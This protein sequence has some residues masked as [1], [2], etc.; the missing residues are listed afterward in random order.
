[1][2][3]GMQWGG[4][5]PFRHLSCHTQTPDPWRQLL[6]SVWVNEILLQKQL[7]SAN[8]CSLLNTI[9]YS[10]WLT[11]ILILDPPSPAPHW[12]C[13]F[14]I[15]IFSQ[16]H[17]TPSVPWQSKFIMVLLNTILTWPKETHS[18]T[19]LFKIRYYL[20]LSNMWLFLKA[21]VF[22]RFESHGPEKKSSCVLLAYLAVHFVAGWRIALFS[23][24]TPVLLDP[25]PSCSLERIF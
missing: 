17:Y 8:I 11:G 23:V 6:L 19:T 25:I 13:F 12:S 10:P 5:R 2:R 22:H 7:H 14:E 24:T 20:K 3:T 21:E 9:L 15:S 4:P 16:V 1:M 18:F